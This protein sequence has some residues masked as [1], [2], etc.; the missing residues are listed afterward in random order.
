M[1]NFPFSNSY[2]MER[3]NG[4]KQGSYMG[5]Y[6]LAFALSHVFGHLGG[7]GSVALFGYEVTMWILA[8]I[9]GVATILFVWLDRWVKREKLELESNTEG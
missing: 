1:L 8:G 9:L 6:L 2:V 7:F 4:G 5:M 3:A